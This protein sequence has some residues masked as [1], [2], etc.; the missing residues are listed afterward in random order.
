MLYLWLN[1]TLCFGGSSF[2]ILIL[3]KGRD[4]AMVSTGGS[5]CLFF[6]LSIDAL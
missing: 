3:Q 6:N 2:V 5:V 4:I 1:K